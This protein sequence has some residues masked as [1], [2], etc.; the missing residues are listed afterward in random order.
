MRVINSAATR[1]SE[2]SG[3]VEKIQM[4]RS[5]A[6]ASTARPGVQRD[7]ISFRVGKRHLTNVAI[8]TIGAERGWVQVIDFRVLGGFAR[9]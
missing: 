3:A 9:V 4:R 6:A 8:L 1:S 2:L 7:E 5:L